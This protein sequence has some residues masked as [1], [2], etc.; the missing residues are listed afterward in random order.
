MARP[1]IEPLIVRCPTDCAT[2]PGSG[3]ANTYGALTY[4]ALFHRNVNLIKDSDVYQRVNYIG[5]L[6]KLEVRVNF[7]C[8]PM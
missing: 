1:G 7:A 4:F 5:L 3:K 6:V 2:R 8:D